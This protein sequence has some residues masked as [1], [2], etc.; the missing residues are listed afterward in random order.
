MPFHDL[1]I[2]WSRITR[3][4]ALVQQ[5]V[6]TALAVALGACQVVAAEQALPAHVGF[7]EHIR[8]ILT[9]HCTECHGGVKQ[10]AELSFVYREQVLPP[11]G[12]VVEPGK[13]DESVLME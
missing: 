7:N 9:K 8:P 10:A 5:L 13:P 4:V 1:P 12:W 6:L 2:S 3:L 11:D